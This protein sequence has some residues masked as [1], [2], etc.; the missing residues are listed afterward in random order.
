MYFYTY[1]DSSITLGKVIGRGKT[2]Q[3]LDRLI[4]DLLTV[5]DYRNEDKK[6]SEKYI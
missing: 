3:T 4:I 2:R 1:Y 6:N 5:D